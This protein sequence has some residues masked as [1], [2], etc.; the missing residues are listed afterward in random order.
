MLAVV[1]EAADCFTTGFPGVFVEVSSGG[2]F[3]QQSVVNVRSLCQRERMY[4]L[5]PCIE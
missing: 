5:T 4:E 2:C 1:V 3:S